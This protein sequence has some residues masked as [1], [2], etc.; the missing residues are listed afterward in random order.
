MNDVDNVNE[1]MCRCGRPRRKVHCPNCGSAGCY[2]LKSKAR[3]VDVEGIPT[4]IMSYQCRGCGR[5]FDDLLRS[6]CYAPS[7]LRN[8]IL[9]NVVGAVIDKK[10]VQVFESEDKKQR[11]LQ[12]MF[13][14]KPRV[15]QGPNDEVGLAPL[16]ESETKEETE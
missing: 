10:A 1:L 12:N 9:T 8:R 11:A 16:T 6:E 4:T 3:I 14:T 7:P 5:P 13:G 15:A 2:A